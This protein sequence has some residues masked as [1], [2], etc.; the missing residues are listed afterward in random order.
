MISKLDIFPKQLSDNMEI[1]KYSYYYADTF[2]DPTAQIYL[3]CSYEEDDYLK[4]I[5]RLKGIQEEYEGRIQ[6]RLLFFSHYG[7]SPPYP[8]SQSF[9]ALK[10]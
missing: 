6:S 7:F 8:S 5:E 4:E 2:L 10:Q 1:Y 9:I 3:E